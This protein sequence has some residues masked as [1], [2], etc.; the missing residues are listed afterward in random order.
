MVV[1]DAKSIDEEIP[2]GSHLLQYTAHTVANCLGIPLALPS[3]CSIDDFR[4][5]IDSLDCLVHGFAVP[6]KRQCKQPRKNQGQK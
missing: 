3:Q 4:R 6:A 1:M 5:S 2:H